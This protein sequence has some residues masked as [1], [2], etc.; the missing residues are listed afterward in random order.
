MHEVR[1]HSPTTPVQISREAYNQELNVL[2]PY[3][4]GSYTENWLNGN[5]PALAI[6]S[7]KQGIIPIF[8]QGEGCGVRMEVFGY[9]HTPKGR[10]FWFIGKTTKK[11]QKN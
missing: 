5:E 10:E 6:S 2:P 8:V 3:M 9:K 4:L 1:E 11:Y 7:K